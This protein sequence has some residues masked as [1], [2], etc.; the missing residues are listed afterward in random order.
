MH[1]ELGIAVRQ[2][3]REAR[4]AAKL[5]QAEVGAD[6]GVSRQVITKWENGTSS[7]N[8]VQVVRL[9]TRYGVSTD[10]LLTGTRT[11]PVEAEPV[12]K[13]VLRPRDFADSER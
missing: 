2:R 4:E 12:V 13:R 7:P 1:S 10:W 5:T 6:L 11:V 9:C 8:P 3:M